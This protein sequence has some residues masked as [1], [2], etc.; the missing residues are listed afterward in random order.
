MSATYKDN[1]IMAWKQVKE[2]DQL[3]KYISISKV[4]N[5]KPCRAFWHPYR[6]GAIQTVIL[7]KPTDVFLED[8]GAVLYLCQ[9]IASTN[10]WRYD[11][12][13]P[14]LLDELAVYLPSTHSGKVDM[15]CLLDLARV[16][17]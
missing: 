13:R 4:H 1:G 11:Y 8:E 2:V 6:F 17:T 3:Q 14:V 9:S 5:T 10:A 12:A 7:V 16:A 15:R